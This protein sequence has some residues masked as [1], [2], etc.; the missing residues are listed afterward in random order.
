MWQSYS[1]FLTNVLSALSA[2]GNTLL[3]LWNRAWSS[4]WKIGETSIALRGVVSERVSNLIMKASKAPWPGAYQDLRSTDKMG[5]VT[6]LGFELELEPVCNQWR[7]SRHVTGYSLNGFFEIGTRAY[8]VRFSMEARKLDCL[9]IKQALLLV[10]C[11]PVCFFSM[12][13]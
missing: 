6:G 10:E 7:T 11:K 13:R 12:F 2:G 8:I 5:N 1:M 3:Q 4:M 9:R